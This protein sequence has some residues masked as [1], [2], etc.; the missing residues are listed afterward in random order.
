MFPCKT[1]ELCK[2][3]TGNLNAS[4]AYPPL[5]SAGVMFCG[6]FKSNWKVIVSSQHESRE[7]EQKSFNNLSKLLFQ[8]IHRKRKNLWSLSVTIG[9]SMHSNRD[10][11]STP[12]YSLSLADRE[13]IT[14]LVIIIMTSSYWLWWIALNILFL[15][16][17]S[18]DRSAYLN[19]W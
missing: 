18:N 10:Q 8:L 5:V 3:S 11:Q 2:V 14:M 16:L 4:L 15:N 9:T 19:W 1:T 6:L 12:C 13:V 17:L 7:K